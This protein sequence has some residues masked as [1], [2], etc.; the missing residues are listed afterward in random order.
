MGLAEKTYRVWID[1]REVWCEYGTSAAQV[2]SE[3]TA[4]NDDWKYVCVSSLDH[5]ERAVA[6]KAAK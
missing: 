4:L 6:D 1:G 5:K 2:L 3:V